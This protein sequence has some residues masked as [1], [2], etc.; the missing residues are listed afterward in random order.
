[1]PVPDF[2]PGEVLTA[3][4]MDSIGLWLIDA[5]SFTSSSAVNVNNVFSSDYRNYRIVG[6]YTP[7]GNLAGFNL[8]LRA[9][10]ADQF[11]ANYQ[12]TTARLYTNILIDAVGSG[13]TTAVCSN[14]GAQNELASFTIDIFQPN[15][16]GRTVW[17]FD[18]VNFEATSAAVRWWSGGGYKADYVATGFTIYPTSGNWTGNLRVYG[19]RD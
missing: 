1:M 12:H 18:A 2:S 19:Y 7:T 13:Q 4:A 16:N 10:G 17:I 14:G 5:E 9:G 8:R 6:S 11:G 3:A 15:I